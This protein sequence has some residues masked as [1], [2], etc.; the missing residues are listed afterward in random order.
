MEESS[1]NGQSWC[2]ALC[3]KTVVNTTG[4]TCGWQDLTMET[5]HAAGSGKSSHSAAHIN[6]TASV[7]AWDSTTVS[8]W[9]ISL[10]FCWP[11]TGRLEE[12]ALG[13]KW[14]C[15]VSSTDGWFYSFIIRR[16][17]PGTSKNYIYTHR[18]VSSRIKESLIVWR[19]NQDEGKCRRREA[20]K[21]GI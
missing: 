19:Y 4:C 6:F 3:A 7:E 5:M 9:Q 12:D 21:T 1:T 13:W 20:E 15:I 17:C 8:P 18:I 11:A 2:N 14:I 10:S 16:I